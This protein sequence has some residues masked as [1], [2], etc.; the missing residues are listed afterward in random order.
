MGPRG[1]PT[2]TSARTPASALEPACASGG[3][4]MAGIS[5]ILVPRCEGLET[6]QADLNSDQSPYPYTREGTD[7]GWGLQ[8]R[9]E[10]GCASWL[11]FV[12]EPSSAAPIRFRVGVTAQ[13]T[14]NP[15][16]LKP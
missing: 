10:L 5:M 6:K 11:G 14:P 3:P 13:H 1:I 16:R 7:Q 12:L 9:F 2:P 15:N 8:S 4:G